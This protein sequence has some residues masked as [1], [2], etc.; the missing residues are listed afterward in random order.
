MSAAPCGPLRPGPAPPFTL[1]VLGVEVDGEVMGPLDGHAR[2]LSAGSPSQD[3]HSPTAWERGLSPRAP[4][5][6]VAETGGRVLGPAAAAG[7]RH[8]EPTTVFCLSPLN[9]CL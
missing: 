2:G 1:V 3:A 8:D 9:C 5:G 6:G 7:P 4:V